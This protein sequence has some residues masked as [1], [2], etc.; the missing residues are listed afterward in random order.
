MQSKLQSVEKELLGKVLLKLQKIIF[1][2]MYVYNS[3]SVFGSICSKVCHKLQIIAQFRGT[4]HTLIIKGL[5]SS[6]SMSEYKLSLDF[7]RILTR[8]NATH[9]LC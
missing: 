2:I 3:V 9:S 6:C 4:E 8:Y 5:F 7:F 1:K